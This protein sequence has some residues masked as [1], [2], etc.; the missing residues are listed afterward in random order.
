MNTERIG[1]GTGILMIVFAVLVDLVQ[2]VLTLF[3]VGLILNTL[4]TI[5][6]TFIFG[7]W[8]AACG[9]SI[10]KPKRILGFLVT[11]LGE[12]TPGLDILPFWTFNIGWNVYREWFR[13]ASPPGL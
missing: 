2:F 8:F 7:L 13:P 4:I 5:V 3:L 9:V 11:I 10:L 6:W 12:L 1:L